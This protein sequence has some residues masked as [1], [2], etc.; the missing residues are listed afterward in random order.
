MPFP[1]H[2]AQLHA[3]NSALPR[4]RMHAQQEL[5]RLERNIQTWHAG[6]PHVGQP[7]PAG[8]AGWLQPSLPQSLLPRPPLQPPQPQLPPQPSAMHSSATSHLDGDELAWQRA[9]E[10]AEERAEAAERTASAM[11]SEAEM[12]EVEIVQLRRL[13]ADGVEERERM[14]AELDASIGARTTARQPAAHGLLSPSPTSHRDAARQPP[15]AERGAAA[16]AAAEI[17]HLRGVIAQL[18]HLVASGAEERQRLEAQRHEE[19]AEEEAAGQRLWQAMQQRGPAAHGEGAW[20]SGGGGGGNGLLS[21]GGRGGGGGAAEAEL[22]QLRERLWESEAQLGHAA[23]AASQ[24]VLQARASEAHAAQLEQRL[25]E[26]ARLER[27]W[28]HRVEEQAARHDLDLEARRG[29]AQSQLS[30]VPRQTPLSQLLAENY[31]ERR[32]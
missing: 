14:R 7:H 9:I 2:S 4:S 13:V 17:V 10:A 18:Q 8:P 1:Q 21:Q 3:A 24:L 16:E 30:A 29:M 11:L 5:L 27:S 26:S 32:R 19:R 6:Q 15:V 12:A 31:H 23:A 22:A 20:R 28:R 25:A